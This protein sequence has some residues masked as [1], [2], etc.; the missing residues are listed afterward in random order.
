M[1]S[2]G[3]TSRANETEGGVA[4]SSSDPALLVGNHAPVVVN[5]AP[6]VMYPASVVSNSA[7]VVTNPTP[8][9]ANTALVVVNIS[10]VVTNPALMVAEPQP[11]SFPLTQRKNYTEN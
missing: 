2:L 9:V 4:Y 8:V 1:T 7:P 3:M 11:L 5:L 6:V 10:P